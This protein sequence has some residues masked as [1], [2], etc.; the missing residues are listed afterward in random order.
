[1]QP[2]RSRGQ[3]RRGSYFKNDNCSDDDMCPYTH[4][5]R[6]RQQNTEAVNLEK[7]KKESEKE[8]TDIV[9]AQGMGGLRR[10]TP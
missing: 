5:G 1:M 8:N 7:M 10:R 4:S 9:F 2:S 6:E 3:Q